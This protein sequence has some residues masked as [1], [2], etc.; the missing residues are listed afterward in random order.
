MKSLRKIAY[1][2][3]FIALL[4]QLG[5]WHFL[6]N[7]LNDVVSY[8]VHVDRANK[9]AAQILEQ[10]Q[11][12]AKLKISKGLTY[13]LD[14]Y[15]KDYKKVEAA[16]NKNGV[17]KGYDPLYQMIGD[18]W[19]LVPERTRDSLVKDKPTRPSYLQGFPIKNTEADAAISLVTANESSDQL[20]RTWNAM[21][22]F[23][24]NPAV[25]IKWYLK[26]FL[27]F[28]FLILFLDLQDKR[29]VFR[30][31]LSF[32]LNLLLYP[33]VIIRLLW[34]I[35]LGKVREY[36]VEAQL[37]RRSG[38]WSVLSDNE[39]KLIKSLARGELKLSTIKAQLLNSHPK[40]RHS[41][42][43]A[44]GATILINTV[45][46]KFTVAVIEVST[47]V[48]IMQHG[49]QKV[50]Q[51][52]DNHDGQSSKLLLARDVGFLDPPLQLLARMKVQ[53]ITWRQKFKLCKLSRK[54]DHI[55]LATI[56]LCF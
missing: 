42:L 52:E 22:S 25:L 5:V 19:Q 11:L 3:W 13:G 26:Y 46:I 14:D 18:L 32:I 4:W 2:V 44:L 10:C 49:P 48:Q 41:L 30:S 17:W 34:F 47:I 51:L 53:L 33:F 23:I 38:L 36:Y 43:M 37:R 24:E 35:G 20:A 55:P 12:R 1:A 54:I 31:P 39:I 16:F 50:L 40:I 8:Q 6:A 21:W 45:P 9:E 7:T 28:A 29:L 15:Y 56:N 27:I